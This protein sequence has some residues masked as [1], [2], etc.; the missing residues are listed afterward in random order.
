MFHNVRHFRHICNA[1]LEIAVCCAFR[2]GCHALLHAGILLN[3]LKIKGNH[4]YC[5][6]L[7]IFFIRS[8]VL[9]YN[10]VCLKQI[11]FVLSIA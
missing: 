8:G 4:S 11:G 2:K 3:I 9:R 5:A 1:L 10:G 7:T 6:Y